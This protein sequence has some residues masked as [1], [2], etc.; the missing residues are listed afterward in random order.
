MHKSYLVA[1]TL[2]NDGLEIKDFTTVPV[3]VG[4]GVL[5]PVSGSP[6]R[7]PHGGILGAPDLLSIFL[8][9]GRG[10]GNRTQT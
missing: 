10:G 2:I 8:K 7:G 3:Y 1:L 6:V 4:R 5:V 9:L